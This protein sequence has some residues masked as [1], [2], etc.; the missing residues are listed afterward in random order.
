MKLDTRLLGTIE[1]K[2]DDII[3][4][5]A[6]LPGFE[7]ERTFLLLPIAESE[8]C[9]FCLQSTATPE[10][11]FILLNP[12]SLDCRYAPKLQSSEQKMLGVTRDEE[13][14]FY[15]LCSLK[16]PVGESTVNM[17]CPIAYNPDT[18]TAYQVILEDD[19]LHMHHPL[20]EFSEKK[21]D[22]QC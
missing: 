16:R 21:E 18:Q 3:T 17:K 13:L 22:V 15:V 19:Q 4:F 2:Q 5:P 14:C 9:L 12:F 11:S 10:L 8:N 1:Y 6:G 20:S 7:A